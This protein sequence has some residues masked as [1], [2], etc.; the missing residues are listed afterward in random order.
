MLTKELKQLVDQLDKKI[1]D[2]EEHLTALDVNGV[3][4]PIKDSAFSFFRPSEFSKIES[5]S[6]FYCGGCLDMVVERVGETEPQVE[7]LIDLPIGLRTFM[8]GY[9]PELIEMAR[10]RATKAVQGVLDKFDDA[11]EVEGQS[12]ASSRRNSR[13]KK[14]RTSSAPA[15]G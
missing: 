15:S 2:A 12:Q 1:L 8:E 4:L 11:L 7:L 3:I 10:H 14:H 9:I 5:I 13:Q 6:L